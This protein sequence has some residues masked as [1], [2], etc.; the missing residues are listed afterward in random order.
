MSIYHVIETID[1]IYSVTAQ[2]GW[3]PPP[4]ITSRTVKNRPKADF[5]TVKTGRK[6][7]FY[8]PINS[9]TFQMEVMQ[10]TIQK[11]PFM[12]QN[13]KIFRAFGAIHLPI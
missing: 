7:G 2:G 1:A 10:F 9:Q 11:L 12:E 3:R 5:W 8:R 13:S 4:T 6:A